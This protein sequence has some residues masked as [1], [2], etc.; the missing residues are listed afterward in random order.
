MINLVLDAVSCIGAVPRLQ[1][2]RLVLKDGVCHNKIVG[3]THAQQP[4]AIVRNWRW[5]TKSA[6]ST[7][8]QLRFTAQLSIEVAHKQQQVCIGHILK[9]LLE[10]P[11]ESILDI[12]TCTVCWGIHLDDSE[13]GECSVKGGCDDAIT[14]R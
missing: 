12:R 9:L 13:G 4:G 1:V 3:H 5:E 8:P 11:I 10:L 6:N 14:D 7:T 2:H